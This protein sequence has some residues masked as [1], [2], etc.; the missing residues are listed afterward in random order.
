MIHESILR[1]SK[2][3]FLWWALGLIVLS[4]ALYT[5]QGG[6]QPPNGGTWQGY[7]LGTIGAL[8]IV[9]L[10]VLGIRKRSYSSTTGSVPG[11]A[12][13]TIIVMTTTRA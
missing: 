4:V 5:T 10:A 12:M 2:A 6:V 1:F 3:R 8:L 7:V 9:W 13:P 11:W